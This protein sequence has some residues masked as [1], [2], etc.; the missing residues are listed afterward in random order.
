MIGMKAEAGEENNPASVFVC[1]K[2]KKGIIT[3][4][5]NINVKKYVKNISNCAICINRSDK[6]C[7]IRQ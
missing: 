2:R 1:Q 6:V 7:K 3:I 4:D 5:C